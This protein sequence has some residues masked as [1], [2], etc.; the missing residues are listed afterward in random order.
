MPLLALATAVLLAWA[1][2]LGKHHGRAAA[3]GQGRVR[4]GLG[5]PVSGLE[6]RHGSLQASP[7]AC[8]PAGR[9]CVVPVA[10]RM[11]ARGHG[12]RPL[13]LLSSLS[14]TLALHREAQNS[15]LSRARCL[16]RRFQP[17]S[18]SPS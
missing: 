14:R 17:E 3:A 11:P 4:L 9:V 7:S 6:R 8:A 2:A 12:R 18:A 10:V 1:P 15:L 16:S 5:T 13:P